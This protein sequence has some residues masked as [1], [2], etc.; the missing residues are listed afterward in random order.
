MT[1][2]YTPDSGFLYSTGWCWWWSTDVEDDEVILAGKVKLLLNLFSIFLALSGWQS[3]LKNSLGF[4]PPALFIF[5]ASEFGFGLF[6]SRI[7]GWWLRS[8]LFPKLS[9]LNKSLASSARPVRALKKDKPLGH[10]MSFSCSPIISSI[11][12][13]DEWGRINIWGSSLACGNPSL[14][15]GFWKFCEESKE[16]AADGSGLWP[17]LKRGCVE[18]VGIADCLVGIE[19]E[20]EVFLVDEKSWER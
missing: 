11:R 3:K 10:L 6:P 14:A 2:E 17:Q 13:S 16:V 8:P 1:S 15:A 5:E 20:E 7:W 12:V 4:I 18:R 9:G 19:E